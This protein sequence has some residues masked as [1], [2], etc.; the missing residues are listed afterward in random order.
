M[1]VA[2]FGEG[3]L[4]LEYS[5]LLGLVLSIFLWQFPQLRAKQW[6][7]VL[8]DLMWALARGHGLSSR[9]E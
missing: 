1:K 9:V 6:V 4:L 8:A 5:L 7:C 2:F 3:R